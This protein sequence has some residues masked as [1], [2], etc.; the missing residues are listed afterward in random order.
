[1]SIGKY[2]MNIIPENSNIFNPNLEISLAARYTAMMNTIVQP[3]WVRANLKITANKRIIPSV[4]KSKTI[5][6]K[7][8]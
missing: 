4:Q 5:L 7:K 3:Q 1:M 8:I 2:T 6:T